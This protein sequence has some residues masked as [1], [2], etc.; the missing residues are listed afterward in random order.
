MEENGCNGTVGLSKNIQCKVIPHLSGKCCDEAYLL[1]S[2]VRTLSID[3]IKR[4]TSFEQFKVFSPSGKMRL[5]MNGLSKFGLSKLGCSSCCQECDN[6]AKS[7]LDRIQP[8]PP[9]WTNL[10]AAMVSNILHSDK[11]T[12]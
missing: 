8:L 4:N 10:I 12:A 9:S 3:K 7:W 1:V 2:Y 5:S 11:P 6:S